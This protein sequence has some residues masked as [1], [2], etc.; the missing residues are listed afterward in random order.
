MIKSKFLILLR[1][2]STKELKAFE[3]YLNTQHPKKKIA[4]KIFTHLQKYKPTYEGATVSKKYIH[5]K[6]F[7]NA[8]EKWRGV[9]DAPYKLYELLEEFLLWQ[10][11]QKDSYARDK[12]LLDI[13][14]ERKADELFYEKIRKRRAKMTK[15][16]NR[17][18]W[19][20]FEEMQLSYEDYFYVKTEKIKIVKPSINQANEQLDIFYLAAKLK[21]LC[22]IHSRENILGET[23][24]EEDILLNPMPTISQKIPPYC[25]IYQRYLRLIQFKDLATFE[26]L[27]KIL[28][29]NLAIFEKQEQL[30]LLTYLINFLSHQIKLGKNTLLE[31]TLK[32]H[33]I[34]LKNKIFIDNGY[35]DV[36]IYTNIV[37][38]AS[39]LGKYQWTREFIEEWSSFLLE[40][41]KEE[42]ITIAEGILNFEKGNYTWVIEQLGGK[43]FQILFYNLRARG[44]RVLALLELKEYN[45]VVTDIQAFNQFL[46]RNETLGTLNIQSHKTFLSIVKKLI[47]VNVEKKNILKQIRKAKYLVYKS[48]L[49]SKVQN[50]PLKQS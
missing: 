22:E 10:K 5:E 43:N 48:W 30:V 44:L 41:L 1:T 8:K 32:L 3:K 42:T 17:D 24:L 14:K 50:P 26:H 18:I 31:S 47:D 28:P 12:M 33:Q 38:I 36:A 27:Y 2:L 46:R 23:G 34:G 13:F 16:Q 25:D 45:Q 6:V 20:Y 7:K 9:E 37:D 19:Y 49:L 39:K 11:I 29:E 21:Y 4:I 40:D 35:I 15:T